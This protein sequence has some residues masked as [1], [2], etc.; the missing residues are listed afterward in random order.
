MA[1]AYMDPGTGS[2]IWQ[3]AAAAVIGCLFYLKRAAVW[4]RIRPRL[5]S[6][7]ALGF[8]FA[9]CYAMLASLLTIG[10][11][12]GHPPPRFNDP[13]LVGIVLAAYVYTW[14]SAA[15]LL[16][17]SVTVSAWVLPPYGSFRVVGF[18]EW[19]RLI[20]F[21]SLSVFLICLISRMK[22]RR[23][24]NRTESPSFS[25]HAAAGAD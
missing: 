6:Q 1:H 13:F 23:G 9:T 22:I 2:M 4:I 14:D 17:I 7:R 3:V 19:C 24:F 11:F 5:R 10:L 21:A 8:V 12:N 16:L 20:S 18:E 25:M 15:Y